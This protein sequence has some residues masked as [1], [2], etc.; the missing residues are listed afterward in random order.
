LPL[1]ADDAEAWLK[2]DA[3]FPH[4]KGNQ[5]SAVFIT[6]GVRFFEKSGFDME[7]ESTAA[8]ES[9]I[10]PDSLFGRGVVTPPRPAALSA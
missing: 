1:F 8:G 3:S 4:R 5:E 9:G 6:T 7:A 10:S 2:R